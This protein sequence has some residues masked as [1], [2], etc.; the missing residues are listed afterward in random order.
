MDTLVHGLQ[1]NGDGHKPPLRAQNA[2]DIAVL[3]GPDMGVSGRQPLPE[4]LPFEFFRE[5]PIPCDKYPFR[6]RN[7]PVLMRLRRYSQREP[8]ETS[9]NIGDHRIPIVVTLADLNRDD[10]V[11]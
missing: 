11:L 5:L 6:F 1:P 3:I 9:R 7:R 8:V 10:T 2:D 4:L